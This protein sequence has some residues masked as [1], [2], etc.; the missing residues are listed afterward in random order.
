MIIVITKYLVYAEPLAP[1]FSEYLVNLPRFDAV[2]LFLWV[3]VR[4]ENF[5]IE[6]LSFSFQPW[7]LFN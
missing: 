5:I 1:N 3:P 6:M 2:E 4:Q 7:R